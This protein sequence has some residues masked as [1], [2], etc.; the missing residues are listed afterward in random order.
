MF[1]VSPPGESLFF[2]SP[3]KSNPKKSDPSRSCFLRSSE[4]CCRSDATSMSRSH[5][6]ALP[7]HLP[8]I[9]FQCSESSHGNSRCRE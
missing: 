3:K 2:V 6:N 7:V 1:F 9:F 8:T 5:S 4:N